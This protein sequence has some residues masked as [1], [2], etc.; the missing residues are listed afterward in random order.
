M[1][2]M[3][4]S[5]VITFRVREYDNYQSSEGLLVEEGSITVLGIGEEDA[6]RWL[7]DALVALA[8]TL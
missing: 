7:R 8:E 3:F 4:E 5:V 6:A 2:D 1:Y